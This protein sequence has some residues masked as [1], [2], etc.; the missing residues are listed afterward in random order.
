MNN[1]RRI[2]RSIKRLNKAHNKLLKH[3]TQRMWVEE[4]EKIHAL[5]YIYYRYFTN[6]YLNWLREKVIA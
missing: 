4:D 5:N 3:K 1:I 6:R 2:N